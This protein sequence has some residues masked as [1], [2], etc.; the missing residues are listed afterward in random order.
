MVYFEVAIMM[1]CFVAGIAVGK[2]VH[3]LDK[4][5][6]ANAVKSRANSKVS[7]NGQKSGDFDR[8]IKPEKR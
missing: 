1:L 8:A 4:Q 5:G 3:F 2:Y 6:A 7:K